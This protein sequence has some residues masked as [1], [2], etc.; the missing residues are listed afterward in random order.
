MCGTCS[1]IVRQDFPQEHLSFPLGNAL[2]FLLEH[3]SFPL[4]NCCFPLGSLVFVCA[5]T[6]KALFCIFAPGE[7]SLFSLCLHPRPPNCWEYLLRPSRRGFPL[8]CN[9]AGGRTPFGVTTYL[10]VRFNSISCLF[11]LYVWLDHLPPP[12]K[13][14][15][16]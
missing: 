1:G 11:F 6:L 8:H 3:I 16:H 13:F 12:L 2:V 15:V 10:C 9:E 5:L 7:I 14:Q 4:A